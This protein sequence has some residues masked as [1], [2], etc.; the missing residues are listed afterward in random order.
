MPEVHLYFIY[1]GMVVF[2]LA[3]FKW[4]IVAGFLLSMLG[5][6]LYSVR[7][8]LGIPLKKEIENYIES[9]YGSKLRASRIARIG[10]YSKSMVPEDL[11]QAKKVFYKGFFD[12]KNSFVS[13]G[14]AKEDGVV[15][16]IKNDNLAKIP[17]I[18]IFIGEKKI[19][20][21]APRRTLK[22]FSDIELKKFID[23]SIEKAI[24]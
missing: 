7:E 22:E 17:F 9:E 14:I 5:F 16:D 21:Y 8:P 2:C 13:L 20:V 1:L 12:S 18:N 15:V 6:F 19:D 4:M 23:F 11:T 3:P 24:G 10:V